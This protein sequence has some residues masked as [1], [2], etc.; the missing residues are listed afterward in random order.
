MTKAEQKLLERLPEELLI[1]SVKAPVIADWKP[2]REFVVV[3]NRIRLILAPPVDVASVSVNN[4]MVE[5]KLLYDGVDLK[6]TPGGDSVAVVKFVIDGNIYEFNT[7]K[8]IESALRE[9]TSLD[10]PMIV[11]CDVVEQCRKLLVGRHLFTATSLWYDKGGETVKGRK[12][13]PVTIIDVVPGNMVFPISVIFD[14]GNGSVHSMYMNLHKKR[15]AGVESRTF[16]ALFSI[17][18]PRIKYAH[19]SDEVWQLI[20]SGDVR[21]GMTKEECKLSLGNPTDVEA[22]HDWNSTIDIWRYKDGAFL[23]FEDG[24]LVNFRR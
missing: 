24:L 12:Y 21:N 4:D 7:G 23:R 20:Q 5:K 6:M 22:G 17:A 18:D 11:D 14:S 16:G 3:D 13:W 9:M 19:I 8:N 15:A 2:G 1:D 10:V